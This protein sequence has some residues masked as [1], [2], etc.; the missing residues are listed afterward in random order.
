MLDPSIV[1]ALVNAS[2]GILQKALEL[3]GRADPGEQVKKVIEKSYDE[4]A[5]EITT[6][7]LRVLI[8]LRHAGSNQHPSQVH[9]AVAPML[10]RQ[11]PNGRALEQDLTYRLKFLCLLGLA[12]PVGG[13]EFALTKLGAAFIAK[14]HGDSVRYT[15]AFI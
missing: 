7:S 3:V 6:N 1:V 11:E 10:K 2:G 5:K 15:K 4:L 14:A 8:A 9:D 12:Q 13:S